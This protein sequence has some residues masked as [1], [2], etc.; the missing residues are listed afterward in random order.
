LSLAPL[1]LTTS[2]ASSGDDG[3]EKTYQQC[4]AYSEGLLSDMGLSNTN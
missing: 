1:T 2:H 4:M 3:F